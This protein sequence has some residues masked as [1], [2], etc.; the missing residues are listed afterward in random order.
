MLITDLGSSAFY[1]DIFG[2]DNFYKRKNDHLGRFFRTRCV[3]QLKDRHKTCSRPCFFPWVV[4][5]QI[6]CRIYPAKSKDHQKALTQGTTTVI[7]T[8]IML[9]L[10][11]DLSHITED[12][13]IEILKS[14]FNREEPT[15]TLP[16]NEALIFAISTTQKEMNEFNST[17]EKM[18]QQQHL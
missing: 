13:L 11:G 8:H 10:N 17:E 2:W 12:E 14:K 15:L 9:D 7:P 4:I 16:D 18:Q 3:R 1:E 6:S 5:V